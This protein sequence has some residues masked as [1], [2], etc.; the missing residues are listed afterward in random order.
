[1]GIDPKALEFPGDINPIHLLPSVSTV[2][3]ETVMTRG[4]FTIN[5]VVSLCAN[6]GSTSVVVLCHTSLLYQESSNTNLKLT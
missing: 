1:M 4:T 2:T 6:L 3:T 5:T